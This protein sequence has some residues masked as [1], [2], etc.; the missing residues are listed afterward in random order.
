M[1]LIRRLLG[2]ESSKNVWVCACVRLY[3]DRKREA[4]RLQADN[5]KIDCS[6]STS[7]IHHHR[8]RR[9]RRRRLSVIDKRPAQLRTACLLA[10]HDT[11]ATW[12]PTAVCPGL[13]SSLWDRKLPERRVC[14][15]WWR[16]WAEMI[17]DNQ[18]NWSSPS[19]SISLALQLYFHRDE[20]TGTIASCLQIGP[21]LAS[22]LRLFYE[23][24]NCT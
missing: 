18:E 16:R 14:S 10:A 5:D 15:R 12:W 8:R 13:P 23:N 4:T 22:R 21:F 20:S 19:R 6:S 11:R 9:R 7:T 3:S 24:R 17:A 1:L 2:A